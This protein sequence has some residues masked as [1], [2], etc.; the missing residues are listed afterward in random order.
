MARRK[1]IITVEF[2]TDKPLPKEVV[3]N[4]AEDMRVQTD[5]L[6]DG[7]YADLAGGTEA[8]PVYNSRVKV[9]TGLCTYCGRVDCAGC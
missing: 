4:L 1:Y 3:L 6:W 8:V 7:T 2:E 5:S 9:S